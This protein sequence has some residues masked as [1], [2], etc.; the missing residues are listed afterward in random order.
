MTLGTFSVRNGVLINILMVTLLILGVFSLRR[1]PQEQFAEVPFYWA[2]IAVPF[3]GVSAEDVEQLLSVPIENEMQGLDDVD[4]IRSV[5]SEGLSLVSVR[6]ESDISSERFD[7]LFQDVRTRFSRVRLPEGTLQENI[8]S[9]SSNDFAPVIEV[10]LSGNSDYASLVE[11]AEAMSDEMS[12]INEVSS[13]ELVGARDRQVSIVIDQNR[14]D[15]LGLTLDNVVLALQARNLNVPGGT[16][17]TN[18]RD[19]LVR[20]VGSVEG[21]DQFGEVIVKR[22]RN[23]SGIVKIR[24][25]ASVVKEYED[26]GSEA[27]FNG[28]TSVSIRV[29]KIPRG[30]SVKIAEE[31]KRIS[32]EWESRLT[33]DIKITLLNDS[34]VQIRSSLD[35]LLNNALFGLLLLVLILF[36]FVGLRN[37]VMT[38]IGIPLTFAITFMILDVMG[39]T[40][41]SNTL[42]GLVLVLGLIVDHAIVIIENSFRLQQEG[43]S[44]HDAAIKGTD[45]VVF[46]VIAAT[47]TTVAAFLPLMI[48]PGTIG[49]FLRVIPLTVSIALIA[50][51]FEA[52]VFI[53]S[54]YAEWPGGKKIRKEGRFFDP[55][56]KAYS[57]ILEKLYK[58]KGLAVAGAMFIMF[59][60]LG[61]T[62]AL[63]IDLF[64][65]EDY[66]Y[67]TIDIEMPAGTTRDRTDRVVKQYE[68][69]LFPLAGN[70]EVVSISTSIGFL[71][72]QDGNTSQGNVAQILVDLTEQ[73]DGR[74]RSISTIM[75]DVREMTRSIPGPENVFFRKAVNGPPQS[76]PVSYQLFGDNLEGLKLVSR[77]IVDRLR[78]YPELLNIEDDFSGG[79][80]EL[81]VI[82]NEERAAAYG[83]SVL[84]IGQYIRAAVDGIQATTY[85]EDNQS[86][87]VI[88][89]YE[90][91]GLFRADQ[92]E[93]LLIPTPAGAKVPFSA[94][95]GIEEATSLSTIQRVDGKRVVSISAGAYTNET[96]PDINKD[97]EA[98]AAEYAVAYPDQI[99]SVGGEFADFETLIFDILRIFLIGVFLI[100]LILG[101]QFKSYSQ[102]FLI[103][104]SVPMAFA[105]IILYLFVSRTPFSTT[106]LYAGVAL[107]GIAVNDAIVLISFINELREKGMAVAAAVKEA[108][109]TR[110]RPIL[111][112]SLTTIA[113]LLPTAIGI[114]GVSVVWQPMASTI[115]FGLLFSTLTALLLIPLMY[116]L[117]YGRKDKHESN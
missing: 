83:L 108:A 51:T 39:E 67:F 48:L 63:N 26:D 94:V 95:A 13:V 77:A 19:Y 27:R 41:N 80:P 8:S 109:A 73:N 12:R 2:N 17:S 55:F 1:L 53:P 91:A 18:S 76:S 104:L 93:Q 61:L 35:V 66:T 21:V 65:A 114:G 106:V 70:G 74:I 89:R 59:G 9:F 57:R 40:F 37:A 3:P 16:V 64:S 4:E 98:L 60:L 29:A 97:I 78:T 99:L 32:A 87:D 6:F 86:I 90:R 38:A 101:T 24:D 45:Q 28:E 75:G 34:T 103:L 33:D 105:G 5:S 10:V 11:T 110:L 68:E 15:S 117:L 30:N 113:G 82:V 31:V 23:G 62:G 36:F 79:S 44:R 58:R 115:I 81:R 92:L 71:S 100:Y 22:G 25:V 107:A 72:S 69:R 47:A 43:L 88:V 46:P 56:K 49:K 84:T 96:V 50:S 54:H 85:V 116:G 102:P 42:F 52:L 111:L 7:K 112:T 14:L 20:T